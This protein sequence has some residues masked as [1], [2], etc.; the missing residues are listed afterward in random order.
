METLYKT[1]YTLEIPTCALFMSS[2]VKP[3]AYTVKFVIKKMF[4]LP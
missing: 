2:S 1:T 3:V 4:D